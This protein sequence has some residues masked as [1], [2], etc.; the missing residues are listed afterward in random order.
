MVG[1]GNLLI[2]KTVD[3]MKFVLWVYPSDS[4][5]TDNLLFKKAI[6]SEQG[7]EVQ[8]HNCLHSSLKELITV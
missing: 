8:M 3:F 6:E 5:S 4:M 2:S 1:I 7:E